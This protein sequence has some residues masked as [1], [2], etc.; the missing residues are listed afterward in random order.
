MRF[1]SPVY[2]G[3]TIQTEMWLRG[4]RV[5]FQC[6]VLERDVLVLSNSYVDLHSVAAAD[7]ASPSRMTTA[8]SAGLASVPLSGGLKAEAIFADMESLINADMVKK[9]KAIFQWN[10]T[11][12]GKTAGVWTVD[13]KNGDG[14]LYKGDAKEKAGCT[15][16]L[17]DDTLEALVSGKL[18]SMKAFMSG[19]LK[20]KGNMMLA[21][22]LQVLMKPQA[23]L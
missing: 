15:L 5:H 23:K 19:K 20:I 14:A 12:D 11:K 8:P 18:D 17:S 10:I 1:A 2:P 3:E 13:L 6:R 7:T 22:K 4:Q 9:V 16:T 21:Q